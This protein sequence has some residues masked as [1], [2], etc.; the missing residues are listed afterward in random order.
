MGEKSQVVQLLT[1]HKYTYGE[2]MNSGGPTNTHAIKE[3]TKPAMVRLRFIFC[4]DSVC[5]RVCVCLCVRVCVCV[6][7]CVYVYVCMCATLL[8]KNANKC[9]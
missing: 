1:I 7:V 6:C 9:M 4:S 2:V 3:I 8:S 5:V